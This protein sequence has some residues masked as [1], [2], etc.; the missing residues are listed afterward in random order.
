MFLEV[1]FNVIRQDKCTL[2]KIWK[3][4][5]IICIWYDDLHRNPVWLTKNATRNNANNSSANLSDKRFKGK[6]VV[7]LYI[8]K[9]QL[10]ML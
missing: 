10:K 7:F 3:E 5:I 1:M 8:S 9:S 4:I 2:Y 6:S